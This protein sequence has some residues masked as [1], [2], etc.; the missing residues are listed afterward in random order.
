MNARELRARIKAMADTIPLETDENRCASIAGALLGLQDRI[1]Y[2]I[3]RAEHAAAKVEAAALAA[4]KANLP[5]R[6][7]IERKSRVKVTHEAEKELASRAFP[8][9]GRVEVEE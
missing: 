5:A 3:A 2:A 7:Q 6:K 9:P 4:K 1:E 8:A